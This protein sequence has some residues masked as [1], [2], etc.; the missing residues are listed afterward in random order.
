[1][2]RGAAARELVEGCEGTGGR[3]WAL[4]ARAVRNEEANVLRVRPGMGR[5]LQPTA[6]QFSTDLS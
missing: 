6:I 4:E 5:D 1:M 2:D 3:G